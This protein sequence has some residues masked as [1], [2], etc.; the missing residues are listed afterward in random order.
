MF[1]R[2]GLADIP[3]R[4]TRDTS[5]ADAEGAPKR[6]RSPRERAISMAWLSSCTSAPP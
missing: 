2:T 3:E 5:G 4:E 1:M 6:G